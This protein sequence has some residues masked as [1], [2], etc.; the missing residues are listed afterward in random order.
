V[1][2]RG[3]R[4]HGTKAR[5]IRTG[6]RQC[7][8]SVEVAVSEIRGRFIGSPKVVVVDGLR[9]TVFPNDGPLADETGPPAGP[10]CPPRTLLGTGQG[11]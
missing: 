7:Y 2:R 10:D 3:N 5:P 1:D 4:P 8:P 6:E 11:R 9:L